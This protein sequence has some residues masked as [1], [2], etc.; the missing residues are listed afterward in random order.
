MR[1][2]KGDQQIEKNTASAAKRHLTQGRARR[3]YLV[4][5]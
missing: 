1:Q 3:L 5:M 2:L 4:G